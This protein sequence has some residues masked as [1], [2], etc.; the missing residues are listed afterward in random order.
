MLVAGAA[1]NS[2]LMFSLGYTNAKIRLVYGLGFS[3]PSIFSGLEA[4]NYYESHQLSLRVNL[5]PKKR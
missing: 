2:D 3:K 5:N 4:S 1:T